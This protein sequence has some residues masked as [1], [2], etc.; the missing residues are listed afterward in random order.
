MLR[1]G[2]LAIALAA[3]AVTPPSRWPYSSI[4]PSSRDSV[5]GYAR[6][7]LPRK[8]PPRRPPLNSPM[9][10]PAHVARPPSVRFAT[11][12]GEDTPRCVC[13]RRLWRAG[14]VSQPIEP[15]TSETMVLWSHRAGSWE[16]SQESGRLIIWA[17][18][19]TGAFA[20][21]QSA[22]AHRFPAAWMLPIGSVNWAKSRRPARQSG[23]QSDPLCIRQKQRGVVGLIETQGGSVEY[24][25]GAAPTLPSGGWQSETPPPPTDQIPSG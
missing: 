4:P 8:G 7:P 25:H 9:R 13:R 24:P 15:L 14:L 21:L 18:L 6:A 22:A 3:G 16:K 11:L 1:T 12:P 17:W 5:A 10:E 19:V 20:C 23:R 2:S